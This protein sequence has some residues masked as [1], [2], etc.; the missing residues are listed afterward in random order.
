M[1]VCWHVAPVR[2]ITRRCQGVHRAGDARP[3]RD[4]AIL[5][6]AYD[7]VHY[8]D[9]PEDW[10]I[11]MVLGIATCWASSG[12]SP[13]GF[14]ISVS[15]SFISTERTFKTVRGGTSDDLAHVDARPLLVH[16]S[17]AVSGSRCSARKW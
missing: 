13:S 7:N 15:A 16:P 5:P 17:C 12:S 14:S 6:I 2:S 4:D 11:R 1:A 8:K 9:Q 10:N 3:V